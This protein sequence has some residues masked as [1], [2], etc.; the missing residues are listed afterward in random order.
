MASVC[1]ALSLTTVLS[2]DVRAFTELV[3]SPDGGVYLYSKK[4]NMMFVHVPLTPAAEW[5]DAAVPSGTKCSTPNAGTF[6][7]YYG[8]EHQVRMC[9][10]MICARRARTHARRKYLL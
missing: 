10:N 9:C 4:M 2:Q 7:S 8:S 6:D 1:A 5:C 3:H